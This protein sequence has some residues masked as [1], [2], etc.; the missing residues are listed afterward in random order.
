MLPIQN[1]NLIVGVLYNNEFSW[2][3]AD[4]YV[5]LLSLNDVKNIETFLVANKIEE[6]KLILDAVANTKEFIEYIN[7]YK[8]SKTELKEMM[9]DMVSVDEKYYLDFAP[10]L[11]INF[12]EKSFYASD[13]IFNFYKDYLPK[14]I[15][16]NIGDF[17]EK[18]PEVE[19]Y[20]NMIK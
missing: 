1:E 8:T 4:K 14:K 10:S 9:H 20:W 12:D 13:T 3:V 19:Y 16:F 17:L 6:R 11:F 7:Q 5:W 15:T 2:Y 18:I